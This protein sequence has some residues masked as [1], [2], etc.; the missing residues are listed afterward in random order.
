MRLLALAIA[1]CLPMAA[2]FKINPITKKLDIKGDKGD[3]GAAGADGVVQAL[4]GTSN[5]ICVDATDPANPVL[6]VCAGFTIAQ[7]QVTDLTTDLAAKY[8]SGASPAFANI[9]G[10]SLT[11]TAGGAGAPLVGRTHASTVATNFFMG[12]QDPSNVT[13]GGFRGDGK[14]LVPGTTDGCATWSSGVLG[15]TG[16]ACGSGG[17]GGTWG[18]ITGTL[19][20]QT[21]LQS[22]LDAK[23]A[24]AAASFG[25]TAAGLTAQYVD[26]N[27]GSGGSS[28]ANKPTSSTVGQVY[29]VGSGPTVAFGALDLADSD[30]VTGL[31]PDAN[32]ASTI[33]RDSEV[34]SAISA[35]SSVYQPIATGTPTGTKFLRDDNS[36]QAVPG[37]TTT[38]PYRH[39]ILVA[40]GTTITITAAQHGYGHDS[41]LVS[42]YDT[43]GN[44]VGMAYQVVPDA[45]QDGC[46]ST[47]CNIVVTLQTAQDGTLIVNGGTGPA[48]AD[49]SGAPTDAPYLTTA[50]VT[51]LSAESNLGALTTGLL[52]ITVSAGIATPSTAV[53]GTDYVVPSGNITGS[54]ATLTTPRAIGNVSF[55]GSAAIVPETTAVI[56]GTDATSFFAIY[57]S[58]TGNLQAKTDAGATYNAST[59]AAAFTSLAE[60]A[61][62]VPNATDHLG[63]FAATTSAQLR[64]VLSDE[65]GTGVAYF[66]GGALGTP[67]SGTL[68]N[69][70][71]LP[72]SSLASATNTAAAMVVG[73]GASLRTA[74]GIFGVPTGTTLPATCTVGDTFMDT[75]ATTGQR[76]Y[77]CQAT[78]TWALQ[79][80]GGGGAATAI[81][82][83]TSLP[84]TCTAGDVYFKTDA[85]SGTRTNVC[86]AANTWHYLPSVSGTGTA[87]F[88]MLEGTAPGAGSNAGEHNLYF[89]SADSKLKSHENAGSV[90]V[91]ATEG[92]VAAAYQ[93]LDAALTALAGGSDFVAF[94]GPASTTKTFTLP[95]ATAT[96]LTSN[97]AVTVAQGGTGIASGTSGGIP[98]F[99]G[100]T[101][102]ASSGALAA[103][104]VVIGGGAGTAPSTISA[105]TTTTHALFATAGAPAFRA[106]VDGDIPDT[107]TASNY[108]A[109]AGGTLTGQ[110]ITDNLGIEFDES[111]TNPTCSAGNFSIYADLSENK[112]KKCV[113]GSASDLDT[114]G[115]T[116]SFDT[117]T[118]GTNTTAAMVVGSGGSL[119]VSGTG[120]IVATSGDS[121]TSFFSAGTIEDARLP[122]SM[123]D[124]TI[125]GALN[126]PN[127]TGPTVDAAGEIAVD[128]TTD[129][130]QFFGGAKRALSSIIPFSFVIPAPA[131]TDDM[132]VMKA[133][134]GI[135][136]VGIDA[137]IQGGT[138]VIGQLQ[139]CSSTGASCTDLDSDITVDTD[140]AADD[141]TLTDPTIASGAWWGWKTTSVSGTV[142]FL[143][144]TVRARVVAD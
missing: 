132:R 55:D 111:D 1:L 92:G 17:G 14:L 69:A 19:A 53:A 73:S 88:S 142:D 10:S 129:Q 107:I 86:D 101:T 13:L 38:A 81:T 99:S 90:A 58:A 16:S 47:E 24:T 118:G 108:L 39:P 106:V 122:A 9:T 127:G 42:L 31:L 113:N 27:S 97:A 36:W 119:G 120:T 64:G 77:L 41:L 139:E 95:N 33:A 80:D 136:I 103:N 94:S 45:A 3:T 23:L 114:T 89:D 67:A 116:P 62:A 29:R 121:A 144:V 115:G 37:G 105:S 130:L 128:T 60:G 35:L 18:S 26:W 66:V 112:L 11:I 22:A 40:D 32:I 102:I 98:Y 138:N 30:A 74:A 2:Q 71:G 15:T 123:A 141:G 110:L 56:D 135:T 48:G 126:I 93:P 44:V 84:G 43:S 8:G 20:D 83:G 68:T 124:K 34:T 78:N 87:V 25:G 61:N 63:F 51:G 59:G 143:I 57:D 46:T 131:T 117:I 91:Y 7:S 54:A 134:Y 125:T 75:D 49:G 76:F 96:I 50:A 137:I 72:F 140:G 21:D 82:S 133:P 28:I 6:S 104:A 100:S 52:K 65:E 12:V 85:T 109:L 4:V 79:G 5:E 70:T